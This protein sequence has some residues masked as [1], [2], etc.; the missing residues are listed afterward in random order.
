MEGRKI[1]LYL[2]L[3]YGG[4]WEAIYDAVKNKEELNVEE[5]ESSNSKIK[6]NF[7]TIIDSDYPEKLKSIYK[8]PF[9]LFYYGDLE[10]T[11]RRCLTVVGTRKPTVYGSKATDKIVSECC[12]ELCIVSGLAK[13]IDVVAHKTALRNNAKTIA[14][15]GSG[16]EYCYP[17]ENIEVYEKIKENGLLISEYPNLVEPNADHFPFRNRIVAGL[18]RVI[19]VGEAHE[20]SGTSITINAGLQNGSDICCIPHDIF[21]DDC[22]NNII[23]D[24]AYLV[25]EG[26][27]ILDLYAKWK[28][29]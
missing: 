11:K 5:V 23:K 8:P 21:S 12:E 26:K 25:T 16:I 28:N 9:V 19:L 14:V 17:R 20:R 1:L 15:L 6:C 24:G 22:C 13:G 10:L 18:S 2:A 4:D 27:D 3:K 29:S 7:V